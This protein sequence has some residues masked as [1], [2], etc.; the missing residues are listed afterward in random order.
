MFAQIV[1][2]N[3]MLDQKPI[4]ECDLL[5]YFCFPFILQSMEL[6]KITFKSSFLGMHS[7]KQSTFCK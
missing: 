6:Q 5:T 2:Y 4:F 3:L 1:V 7:K